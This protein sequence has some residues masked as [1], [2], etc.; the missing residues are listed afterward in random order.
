MLFF[1]DI[2]FFKDNKKLHA[3]GTSRIWS[4]FLD[5]DDNKVLTPAG[6]S[7]LPLPVSGEN[8]IFLNKKGFSNK[9]FTD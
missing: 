1:F 6:I 9:V 3:S 8:A 5:D 2:A 7:R 4:Q